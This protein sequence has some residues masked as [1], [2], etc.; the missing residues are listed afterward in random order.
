MGMETVFYMSM[1]LFLVS[2]LG[3]LI[4]C[5]TIP[6]FISIQVMA[7][8]AAVNFLNFS[9]HPSS[10]GE[11]ARMFLVLGLLAFYLLQFTLIYYIY[12]NREKKGLP[13]AVRLLSLE[14]SDWW[15]EDKI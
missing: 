2:L 5:H 11:E 4:S 7:A 1:A 9:L 3:L 8:A 6:F 13:E 10:G 15:G 14:K 12:S